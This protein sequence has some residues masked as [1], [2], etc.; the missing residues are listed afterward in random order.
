MFLAAALVLLALFIPCTV[1]GC[2]SSPWL[3]VNQRCDLDNHILTDLTLK[4]GAPLSLLS[5]H[6]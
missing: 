5:A 6:T 4:L 3:P 2:V 1:G